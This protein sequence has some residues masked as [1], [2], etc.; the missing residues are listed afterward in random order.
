MNL[1]SKKVII[2]VVI[3]L[4]LACG[5]GAIF[6]W[7]QYLIAEEKRLVQKQCIEN[8]LSKL[9]EISLGV[10][11]LVSEVQ[12][13]PH[14]YK[15]DFKG[16]SRIVIREYRSIEYE[17]CPKRYQLAMHELINKSVEGYGVLANMP[18]VQEG[19]ELSHFVI[20]GIE[21]WLLGDNSFDKKQRFIMAQLEKINQECEL[22]EHNVR[23]I[24]M[25]YGVTKNYDF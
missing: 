20:Q 19:Y 10:E 8:S 4:V 3:V 1:I 16:L 24:A 15:P 25:N 2:F 21:N 7:K 12:K 6:L 9:E 11:E 22:L 18:T 13:Y 14:R 17:T 5:A 23:A